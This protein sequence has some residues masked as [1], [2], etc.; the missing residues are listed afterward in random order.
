MHVFQDFVRDQV[1]LK[2][3]LCPGHERLIF[4][5]YLTKTNHGKR[6]DI[7]AGPSRPNPTSIMRTAPHL[8]KDL[9]PDEFI[10]ELTMV[11]DDYMSKCPKRQKTSHLFLAP[12]TIEPD[13]RTPFL[14]HI[15][16]II[17]KGNYWPC[18]LLYFFRDFQCVFVQVGWANTPVWF[19]DSNRGKNQLASVVQRAVK[20][21]DPSFVRDHVQGKEYRDDPKLTGYSLRV[22][23]SQYECLH[24]F[25]SD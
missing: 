2:D 12:K 16:N 7:R 9:K 8:I 13:V 11:F 21:V 19:A 6:K 18:C 4:Y 14:V 23:V 15:S 22:T 5:E 3:P 20:H 17:V 25:H 1:S 10:N 24:P